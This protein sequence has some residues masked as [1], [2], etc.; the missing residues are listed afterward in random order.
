MEDR[1]YFAKTLDWIGDGA[2]VTARYIMQDG[3]VVLIHCGA[4]HKRFHDDKFPP[5]KEPA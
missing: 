3:Q 2:K 4:H 5:E 1:E